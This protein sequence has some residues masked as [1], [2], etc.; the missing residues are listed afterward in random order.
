MSEKN[1]S[2]TN[3]TATSYLNA[4]GKIT[5]TLTNDYMFRAILQR[6]LHVLK[7]LT[8][9]MLHIDP[10]TVTD[11]V[12]TNPIELGQTIDNKEF[13]LDINITLNNNTRIN[14]EMQVE[15]ELNWQ[16][17]S[18][19]Y[20]CRSFDEL[21]SGQ[22]YSETFPVYHIGFLD[23][24][25]F[26]DEAEFYA[27]YKLI[28]VKTHKVFS[29]KFNL[30]VVDLTHIELATEEDRR[31]GM[32]LWARRFKATTWEEIKMLAAQNEYLEEATQELYKCNSD[33]II[34]QQC[35]ARE[36]YY[37]R[38]RT[39]EKALK[40]A[41]EERDRLVEENKQLVAKIEQLAIE[42]EQLATEK[43]QLV[44]EKE[45]LVTEK[46]QLATKMEEALKL[47]QL[48][49]AEIERLKALQNE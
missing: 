7:G 3:S 19:S 28:N 41:N 14:L 39:R 35:R 34:R 4:H 9:A 17:R 43:D 37:R 6:N 13:I 1:T 16:D 36:E 30:S 12:I 2:Q 42:K 23:F 32:D 31:Y 25:L 44:T 38:Q 15:N 24:S 22:N 21:Y 11:I 47:V 29:D 27:K 40:D 8:C 49:N 20:L 10:A 26:S 5:Y 45:Q 18:L 48:Q 46:E 33:D